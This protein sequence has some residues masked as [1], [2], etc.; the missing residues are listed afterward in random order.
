MYQ[1]IAGVDFLN[2]RMNGYTVFEMVFA[3]FLMSFLMFSVNLAIKDRSSQLTDFEAIQEVNRVANAMMENGGFNIGKTPKNN[4][5]SSLNIPSSYFFSTE[6]EKDK[7]RIE[8]V[9]SKRGS[10]YGETSNTD[11]GFTVTAWDVSGSSQ[12][13]VVCINQYYRSC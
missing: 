4:P 9:I 11:L 5:Y 3:L 6:G 13:K 12:R 8:V 1:I 10:T 7:Y 2:V